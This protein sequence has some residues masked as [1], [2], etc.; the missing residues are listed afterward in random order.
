[1]ATLEE[2]GIKAGVGR[3]TVSRVLN[4]NG[5]VKKETKDKVIKAVKELEYYPNEIARQFKLNRTNLIVLMVPTIYHPF[6]SKLSECIEKE[7]FQRKYSMIIL[8]SQGNLNKELKILEMTKQKK[9]DGI[10]FV[11]HQIHKN[12]DE[13]LP[14][15]TIDR[16]LNN[17]IP[18]V[19]SDNYNSSV[20][21]IQH[22]IDKGCRK[23]GFLGGKTLVE[24]EVSKRYA[25]YCDM[26]E[27]N[28]MANI[29]YFNVFNHGEEME[30]A[31][32]F[33]QRNIDIDGVFC[34][35]D[36]LA[37]CMYDNALLLNKNI[38]EDLKIIGFDGV[39][40]FWNLHPK[41]TTVVQNMEGI[42][43]SVVE[44]LFKEINNQEYQIE[45]IIS[46]E[47]IIGETT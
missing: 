39:M 20:K 11:T 30:I 43:K 36:T 19:S 17:K 27:R 26:M 33:L 45:T 31:R 38:P 29:S 25:A 42:S 8:C 4:G 10:I 6:F 24:S 9:V 7:L 44:I 1:M 41:L 34:T 40:G 23:I 3:S 15:I 5:Y 16:H 2:V 18:Y 46:A 13:K 47:I 22:L 35:S 28:N 21:A 14:I 32:K 37:K 12:I